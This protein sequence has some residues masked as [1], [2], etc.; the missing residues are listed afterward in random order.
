MSDY[1]QPIAKIKT[2]LEDFVSG[3]RDIKEF[4]SFIAKSNEKLDELKAAKKVEDDV[5][6]NKLINWCY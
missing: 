4:D 6:W 2:D 5:E 1:Q 3:K